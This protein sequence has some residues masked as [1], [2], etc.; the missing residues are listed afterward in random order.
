MNPSNFFVTGE[1]SDLSGRKP[2]RKMERQGHFGPTSKRSDKETVRGGAVPAG[3]D[4]GP[5]SGLISNIF[6]FFIEIFN[7]WVG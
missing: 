5:W 2:K 3:L 1:K 4:P 7:A 6:K